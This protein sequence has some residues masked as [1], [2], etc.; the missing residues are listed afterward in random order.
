M[1]K[2]LDYT[3]IR[4]FAMRYCKRYNVPKN[5]VEDAIGEALLASVQYSGDR[6][7]ITNAM[8]R[9]VKGENIYYKKVKPITDLEQ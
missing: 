9:Y 8:A 1:D 4:E 3:E 5:M 7:Q 2:L 6:R